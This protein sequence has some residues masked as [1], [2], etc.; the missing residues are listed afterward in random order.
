MDDFFDL[1]RCRLVCRMLDCESNDLSS[2]LPLFQVWRASLL[3]V[4]EEVTNNFEQVNATSRF[5]S[6]ARPSVFST[7]STFVI[8]L[9][10]FKP[11]SK[12]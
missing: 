4:V 10:S 8:H 5:I 2:G 9:F 3:A 12:F 6:K 7:V 1:L 11:K